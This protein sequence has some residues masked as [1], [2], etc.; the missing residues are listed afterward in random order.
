AHGES[1]GA[2]CGRAGDGRSGTVEG[3]TAARGPDAK[4]EPGFVGGA[5]GADRA[6]GIV[7]G[8]ARIARAAVVAEAAEGVDLDGERAVAA[9]GGERME[10]LRQDRAVGH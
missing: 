10:R 6:E 7:G 1:A 2:A 5:G 4:G 3:N 8:I 9:A